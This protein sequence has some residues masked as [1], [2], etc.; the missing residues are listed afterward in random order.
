MIPPAK[1]LE[2]RRLTGPNLLLD[3]PAVIGVDPLAGF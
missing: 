2:V 3:H 1:L